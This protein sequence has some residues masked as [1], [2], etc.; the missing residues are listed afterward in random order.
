M[1]EPP[2]KFTR[3]LEVLTQIINTRP[4]SVIG[5][6]DSLEYQ[7]IS[8]MMTIIKLNKKVVITYIIGSR[9]NNDIGMPAFVQAVY[10]LEHHWS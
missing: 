7:A 6:D 10:K 1:V 5:S 9:E 4:Y 3:F 8:A 2:K